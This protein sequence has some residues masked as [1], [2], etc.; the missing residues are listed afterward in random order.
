MSSGREELVAIL[1]E[2]AGEA[3]AGRTDDWE[4]KTLPAYLEALAAWLGAYENAYINTDRVVPTDPWE[5]LTAAVQAATI[6][7]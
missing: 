1:E 4:N 7:E 2:L 3:R 5:I 6:Y